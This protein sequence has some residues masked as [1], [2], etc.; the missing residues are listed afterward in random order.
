[1][2]QLLTWQSLWDFEYGTADISTNRM[3]KHFFNMLKSVNKHFLNMLKNYNIIKT[4]KND[5]TNV[6]SWRCTPSKQCFYIW[7][8]VYKQ[9][10]PLKN[11]MCLISYPSK[12]IL[13]KFY[14]NNVRRHS[15]PQVKL[16]PV[17]KLHW[18]KNIKMI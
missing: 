5:W 14:W 11:T 13:Y 3:H 15:L 1:M 2:Y 6:K 10:L 4:V 16:N 12:T 8:Q 7:Y 18:H 9:F 17:V